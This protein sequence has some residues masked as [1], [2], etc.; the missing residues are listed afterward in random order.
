MTNNAKHDYNDD[1]VIRVP[2]GHVANELPV[3]L[4]WNPS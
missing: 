1:T 3:L 4:T 2:D